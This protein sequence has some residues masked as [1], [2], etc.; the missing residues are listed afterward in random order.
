MHEQGRRRRD[1]GGRVEQAAQGELRNLEVAGRLGRLTLRIV[2]G[3]IGFRRSTLAIS[4]PR[5]ILSAMRW[6]SLA[7]SAASLRN[8]FAFLA[9][10]TVK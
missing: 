8:C 9:S 6:C 10:C 3:D 4:P 5:S 1:G 7:T 2:D